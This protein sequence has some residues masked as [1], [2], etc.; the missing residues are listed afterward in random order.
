AAGGADRRRTRQG[1]RVRAP[2]GGH[3]RGGARRGGDRRGG[4]ADRSGPVPRGARRGGGGHGRGGGARGGAGPAGRRG[5][6][7]ARLLELRHV[8]QLRAPGSSVPG[9]G[10]AGGGA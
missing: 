9:G 5:G 2:G 7:V 8:P 4:P 1:R 10:G 6:A 3:E